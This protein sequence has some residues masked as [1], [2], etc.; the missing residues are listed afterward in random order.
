M[1]HP[2]IS[3]QYGRGRAKTA[4]YLAV[5]A[6]PH[7]GVV[8]VHDLYGHLPSVRQRCDL[9]AQS[10]MSA[11]APDLYD[12]HLTTDESEAEQFLA[13]LDQ[14]LA[15]T[16]LLGTVEYLRRRGV[17]RLG[18][19][20]FSIGGMLA[21]RLAAGVRV[22]A[23]SLYY[24]ALPADEWIPYGCPMQLHFAETDDFDPPELPDAFSEWLVAS[25]MEVETYHYPGAGH[26]FANPDVPAYRPGSAE[27]S[28]ART[29][30]F[31][32]SHLIWQSP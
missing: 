4:G 21:L 19:L 25:G 29:V 24:A 5:A 27:L 8:V 30:R 6:E 15:L 1:V 11:I 10:G 32:G 26:G 23:I 31:L 2:G 13:R 20:G 17:Q 7:G 14:D 16:R 9:L 28:W 22:D 12:G 3:V 18:L